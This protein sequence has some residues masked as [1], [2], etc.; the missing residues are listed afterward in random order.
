MGKNSRIVNSQLANF[1]TY[2]MYKNQFLTLAQNVFVFDGLNK[3]IDIGYVNKKL[4]FNGSIA[5]FYDE[6]IGMVLA[7]P[8]TNLGTLDIYGRPKKIRVYGVNN[9]YQR[10]L[11]NTSPNILDHFVIMYDNLSH[12]PLYYDIIQYAER[13]A[14]YQRAIDINILQQKTPRIWQVPNGQETTLRNLLNNVDSNIEQILTYKSL[15]IKNISCILEPAPFVAD[16]IYELKERNYNEFLRDIGITNNSY[17]K[18]E[19][20]I[21]D[22]ISVMQG[23]TVASRYNRFEARKVACEKINGLWGKL[24][25]DV[26]VKYFDNVPKST[27]EFEEK[28]DFVNEI[29]EEDYKQERKEV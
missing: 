24:G 13:N 19:R 21:V 23:G 17:Q 9:G 25:V 27:D 15:D 12:I 26:K 5:F 6:I 28:G 11:D 22:E 16:K 18:K 10:T 14:C 29:F 20:Q 3:F 1:Q 2:T 4:L 8:Y 7:L